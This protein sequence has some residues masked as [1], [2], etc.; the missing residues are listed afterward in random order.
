MS[1]LVHEPLHHPASASRYLRERYGV[2]RSVP[3]LASER[4]KGTGPRFMKV[5]RNVVYAQSALDDFA[6]QVLSPQEFR[7]TAEAKA[8]DAAA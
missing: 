7:S 8:F 2:P 3:T 1:D 5:G 6:K 4:H